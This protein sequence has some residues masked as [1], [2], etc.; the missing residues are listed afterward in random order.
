MYMLINFIY[1]LQVIYKASSVGLNLFSLHLHTKNF[2]CKRIKSKPASV[3]V[4]PSFWKRIS[5]ALIENLAQLKLFSF[6]RISNLTQ[7]D[8]VCSHWHIKWKIVSFSVKQKLH[9]LSSTTPRSFRTEL[10]IKFCMLRYSLCA[11]LSR[12]TSRLINL[13]CK[14]TRLVLPTFV[15]HTL[16]RCPN[17]SL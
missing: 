8:C 13:H 15:C 4:F 1:M 12:P 9:T 11:H 7:K 16:C 3:V 14:I 5:V 17:D 2:A 10:I 6:K